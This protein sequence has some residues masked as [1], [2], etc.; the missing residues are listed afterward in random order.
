MGDILKV[1]EALEG[2]LVASGVF[3]LGPR[4]WGF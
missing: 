4:I 2:H 3:R 1:L